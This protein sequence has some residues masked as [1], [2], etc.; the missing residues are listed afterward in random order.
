MDR[1]YLVAF[2]ATA[3]EAG[4]LRQLFREVAAT[5]AAG[6]GLLARHWRFDGWTARGC[7]LFADRRAAERFAQAPAAVD[8]AVTTLERHPLLSRLEGG[9]IE[10]VPAH[11]PFVRP[12]FIVSAPRAGSTLLYELLSACDDLWTIRGESHGV[13]EGVPRLHPANRG[14]ESHGLS[15]TDAVPQTVNPLRAG[16]LVDLCN[17][18]GRRYLDLTPPERPGALR[19]LEKTPENALRIPF[20]NAVFPDAL[21]VFLHRDARD[22]VASIREAW[23]HDGFVNIPRLPGWDRGRWHLI[24]PPGWRELNGRPLMDVAVHQWRAANEAILESLARLPASRWCPIEYRELVA[25]PRTVAE[26]LCEFLGVGFGDRLAA[27]AI[28]PLPL[29]GTTVSPPMPGKWRRNPE[30]VEA[31]LAGVE[32]IVAR[33]AAVQPEGTRMPVRHHPKARPVRF[34]C[35]IDE[36]IATRDEHFPAADRSGEPPVVSPYFHYQVGPTIPLALVRRARFR[37]RFLADYPVVWLDDP[38]TTILSPFWVRRG[39]VHLFARLAAGELPRAAFDDVVASALI[40]A[41]VLVTPDRLERRRRAMKAMLDRSRRQFAASG[42]C[43]AGGLFHPAL[44]R[45]LARYYREL[46]AA[47]EWKLGDPQ[48]SLRHGWHNE[49]LARFVHHQLTGVIGRVAGEEV[50]PSYAYVSC[51]RA[52]AVLERHVDRKQCEITVSLLVEQATTGPGVEPWPLYFET[53]QGA[54]AVTPAVGEAVVFRGCRLPHYRHRLSDG[55]TSTSLLFHYVP[56]DF[57][58]VLD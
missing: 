10:P 9:P 48:V 6:S 49:S 58:G 37:E 24:L 16:F 15:D 3:A 29:S 11:A 7:Y 51:Y 14:F 57:V 13:I 27:A 21:F 31:A 8:P 45:A 53:P 32:P 17:R 30:F 4:P 36:A 55:C 35:F 47:G 52:G 33:L 26:R 44:V 41:E 43:T 19:L 34:R 54:V 40:D 28:R 2:R 22:N 46:I 18:A 20:L 39:L 42:F 23:D 56:A 38:D 12:V 50:K 5:P 25:D 1:L